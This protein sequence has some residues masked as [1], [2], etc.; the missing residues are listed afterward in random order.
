MTPGA[1]MTGIVSRVGAAALWRAEQA[2]TLAPGMGRPL[3]TGRPNGAPPHRPN[4]PTPGSRD[5][6][7][8]SGSEAVRPGPARCPETG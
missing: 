3:F 7:L 6:L 8:V 5:P 2:S 4:G 1:G